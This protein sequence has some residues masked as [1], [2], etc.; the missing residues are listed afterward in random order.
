MM[1][2]YGVKDCC[3]KAFYFEDNINTGE[4]YFNVSKET[5]YSFEDLQEDIM[6]V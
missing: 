3:T 4:L 6:A 1:E 2:K 5:F